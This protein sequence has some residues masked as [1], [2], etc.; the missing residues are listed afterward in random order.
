[1]HCINAATIN[2]FT[3]RRLTPTLNRSLEILCFQRSDA[4]EI[5]NGII[6]VFYPRLPHNI[7]LYTHISSVTVSLVT[8]RGTE[9]RV[10]ELGQVA[11]RTGGTVS[12]GVEQISI[13][14]TLKI[15]V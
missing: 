13:I 5:L 4:I 1:M 2:I 11:D 8:I 14:S 3:Q 9:C 15:D 10:L 6:F 7:I 12:C